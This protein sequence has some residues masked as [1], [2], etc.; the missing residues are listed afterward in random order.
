MFNKCVLGGPWLDGTDT[1]MKGNKAQV[2]KENG[3]SSYWCFQPINSHSPPTHRALARTPAPQIQH[4][5]T[6]STSTYEKRELCLMQSIIFLFIK[7][8]LQ[9][10]CY[11]SPPR[12]I[13]STNKKILWPAFYLWFFLWAI[14]KLEKIPPANVQR[15]LF[16]FCFVLN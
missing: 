10:R 12:Y 1:N 7:L 11:Y 16:Q 3:M 14:V 15:R 4:S 5:A 13:L 8:L 9:L 6:P 2:L